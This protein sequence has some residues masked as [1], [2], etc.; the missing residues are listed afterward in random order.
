VSFALQDAL[1]A[2]C[3][4]I[5]M[6]FCQ[7]MLDLAEKKKIL[8]KAG[9][10]LTFRQ[11]DCLALPFEDAS[12]DAITIAFGVRNLVGPPERDFASCNE[13]LRKAD[14]CLSSSFLCRKAGLGLF[15]GS[16]SNG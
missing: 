8:R 15:C 6:D 2:S 14:R 16:I 4:I 3:E 1:P 13:S 9:D 12:A 7:P 5:G 10:N 11:G